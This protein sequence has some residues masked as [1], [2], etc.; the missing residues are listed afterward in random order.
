MGTNR[1]R[2]GSVHV[3]AAEK[4]AIAA[5]ASITAAHD[6]LSLFLIAKGKT[7]SV[8]QSQLGANFNPSI[9]MRSGH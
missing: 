1:R 3:N 7:P 2:W 8:E 4:E 9:V 6:K 5:L